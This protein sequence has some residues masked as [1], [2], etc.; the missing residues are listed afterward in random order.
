VV[1]GSD[2]VDKISNLQTDSRD[3]P[4]NDVVIE[5]V[6]IAGADDSQESTG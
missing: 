1:Q 3:R 6:E 4:A 2:I 5:S